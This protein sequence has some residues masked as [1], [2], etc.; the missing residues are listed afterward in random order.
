[1]KAMMFLSGILYASLASAATQ[2][3][4]VAA[5]R[6]GAEHL[7]WRADPA[8]AGALAV[9]PGDR[10][11]TGR[12]ATASGGR[13]VVESDFGGTETLSL[14][15][16]TRLLAGARRQDLHSGDVV[17]VAYHGSGADRTADAVALG[18][19]AAPSR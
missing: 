11:V 15:R 1:M 12:L 9:H 8:A 13:L 4:R 17:S 19:R 5:P 2:D 18:D 6:S 16:D 14:S 10:V 7:A 3:V